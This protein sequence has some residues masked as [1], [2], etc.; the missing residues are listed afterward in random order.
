MQTFTLSVLG[1]SAPQ[2]EQLYEETLH[3]IASH[4]VGKR[5]GRVEPRKV[6]RR[7]SKYPY[8]TAPRSSP[9]SLAA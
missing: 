1:A 9:K 4:R 7:K 2:A 3:V 5:P 8:L 6:K